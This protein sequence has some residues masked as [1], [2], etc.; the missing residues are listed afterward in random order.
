[1]KKILLIAFLLLALVMSVVACTDEDPSA[2]TTGAD[3]TAQ[4][5]DATQAPTEA[6]DTTAAEEPTDAL[7]ETSAEE[8]TEE[9]TNAPET[10]QKPE[11][12]TEPESSTEPQEPEPAEKLIVDKTEY[13]VGEPI[14]ITAYGSGTDWV[15]IATRGGDASIGW[16][17]V[18]EISGQTVNFFEYAHDSNGVYTAHLPAGEYTVYLI[19]DDHVLLGATPIAAIDIV[20]KNDYR[21]ALMWDHDKSIVT[22]LSFDELRLNN[23]DGASIFTPGHAADWNGV[24]TLDAS[25]TALYFWGWVG[26]KGD[27]GR[28]GYQIDDGEPIF[29][30]GYAVNADDA[31]VGNATGTGADHASRM[32]ITVDLS[33]LNGKHTVHVLYQS[34]VGNVVKLSEFTVLMP[35]DVSTLSNVA[36]GSAVNVTNSFDAEFFNPAFL[37][38]GIW[39]KLP[40]LGWCS[41]TMGTAP[42]EEF[43]V[44]LTL[45]K[46]YDIYRV[47]LKPMM[48]DDGDPFPAA[49]ELQFSLDGETWETALTASDMNVTPEKPAD[50]PEDWSANDHVLPVIYDLDAP[51]SAKFFRI[52]IL[53]H[54]R[55]ANPGYNDMPISQLGEIELLGA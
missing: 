26:V 14:M 47:V 15:G 9:P 27:L 28:F 3:T 50:A 41:Q 45:D 31:V 49:Y 39:E 43:Y 34:A 12:P 40:T 11:K 8:T 16:Y 6:E 52:H 23:G 35:V 44:T 37:T 4:V 33:A 1:M 38:D 54:G 24:A 36:L 46:A 29:D 32:G 21:N 48:W 2:E 18:E 53:E 5:E 55:D 30:A 10:T 51:V 22:H 7:T 17:Y 42:S 19:P 25:T 20:I 13:G